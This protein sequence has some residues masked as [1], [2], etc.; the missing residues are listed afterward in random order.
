[1]PLQISSGF[2]ATALD[3]QQILDSRD[4]WA[5]DL[6]GPGSCSASITSQESREI[7]VDDGP[8]YLDGEEH[9]FIQS[10]VT[11]DAP[12][13][14][15]PRRDVIYIDAAN[16]LAV[17]TGDPK[18]YYPD[19]EQ[20]DVAIGPWDVFSPFPPS[21]ESV[22]GTVVAEVLVPADGSDIQLRDRRMDARVSMSHMQADSA[23]VESAPVNDTD[24]LRLVDQTGGGGGT[25]DN[26]TLGADL[27]G[28]GF[29]IHSVGTLS[30]SSVEVSSAPVSGN[31]A[32]RYTDLSSYYRRSG[33]SLQG[34]MNANGN[35]ITNADDVEANTL[36]AHNAIDI[37]VS[38]GVPS[39]GMLWW[40]TQES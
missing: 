38:D 11:L 9:D 40:N 30:A 39:E 21:M 23:S 35:D 1:M 27:D 3:L 10:T 24:V 34:R 5:V 12:D 26:H 16:Q 17:E 33:D 8:V 36:T 37:P 20:A 4:G 7:Q 19:P 14:T 28:A 22:N 15:D 31:D 29:D 6:T 25:I 18:P 2:G 13:G 32:V